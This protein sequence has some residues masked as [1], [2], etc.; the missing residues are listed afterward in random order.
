MKFN[1][2]FK[3]IN[4]LIEIKNQKFS[5]SFLSNKF[6]NSNNNNNNNLNFLKEKKIIP[7]IQIHKN[8]LEI[9]I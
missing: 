6:S 3:K 7:Q 2:E 5:L 4:S 1:K 8:F 9:F